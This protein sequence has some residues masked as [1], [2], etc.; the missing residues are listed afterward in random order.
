[1]ISAMSLAKTGY[2]R[3]ISAK[4]AAGFT[5]VELL[6]VMALIVAVGAITLP[7]LQGPLENQ[8]LRKAADVVRTQWAKTRIE[9]MQTGRIHVFQCEADGSVFRIEPWYTEGDYLEADLMTATSGDAMGLAGAPGSDPLTDG[10]S[11]VVEQPLPEGVV[12]SGGVAK[13]TGRSLMVEQALAAT[14]SAVQPILFFPDGTTSNAQL[15]LSNRNGQ[16][17][18]LQLRSLTGIAEVSDMM[19][20]EQAAIGY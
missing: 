12:F 2:T 8:R 11:Q 9:S 1:M 14:G 13:S 20:L 6:L 16:C 19:P 10:T 17:V 5:L 7:A 3:H 15:V 4:R 18:V